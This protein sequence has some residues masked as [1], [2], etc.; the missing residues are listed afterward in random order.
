[1]LPKTE[2][3]YEFVLPFPHGAADLR[4]DE[5]DVERALR[6]LHG[7][8][9]DLH[10]RKLRLFQNERQR[11]L[12]PQNKGLPHTQLALVVLPQ[13][14]LE[15]PRNRAALAEGSFPASNL[16]IIEYKV[17]FRYIRNAK[18]L[19]YI[20]LRYIP[21]RYLFLRRVRRGTLYQNQALRPVEHYIV[22]VE[23]MR[24]KVF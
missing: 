17:I 16:R 19:R 2:T 10:R 12:F 5:V 20:P 23:R 13:Q 1:M 11:H 4:I 3:V 18:P 6:K 15:Q 24:F 21:L 14:F 22:L 8:A 9:V 7:V